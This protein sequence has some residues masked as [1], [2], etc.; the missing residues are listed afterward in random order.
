VQTDGSG[1][2]EEEEVHRFL[3]ELSLTASLQESRVVFLLLRPK[4]STSVTYDEIIGRSRAPPALP[5][6]APPARRAWRRHAF[7]HPRSGDSAG[8][9]PPLVLSGHAASLTPY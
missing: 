3:Q 9:P 4:D 6:P 5:R 1:R 2:L 8:A 7:L